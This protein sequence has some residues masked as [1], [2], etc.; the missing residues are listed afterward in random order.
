MGKDHRIGLDKVR[1]GNSS[2]NVKLHAV[3]LF[4]NLAF[5]LSCSHF[6]VSASSAFWYFRSAQ[7]S[8]IK[9]PLRTSLFWVF[10][11]HLGTIAFGSLVLAVVW[12]IRIIAQYVHVRLR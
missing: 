5:L 4:W 7:A 6:I 10:R 1:L 3:S 8:G 9:N 12:V 11:Y 2:L